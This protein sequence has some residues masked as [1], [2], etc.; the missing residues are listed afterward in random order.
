[1]GTALFDLLPQLDGSIGFG[2]TDTPS[3]TQARFRFNRCATPV[4][5]L[6]L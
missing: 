6:L 4:F 1:M 3:D 2:L 5:A